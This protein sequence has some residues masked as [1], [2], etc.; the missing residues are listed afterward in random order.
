VSEAEIERLVADRVL[1]R[2]EID[3][4]QV[5][6]VWGKAIAS[7]ADSRAA[8][9]S[10]NGA[11]QLVYTAALQATVAVLFA[12]GLRPRSAA[13]HY[14][15]F[16]ALQKLGDRL[17]QHAIRLDRLRITRHRSVYE[18]YEVA[19]MDEQLIEARQVVA[20]AL[21]VLRA[22][23]IDARPGLEGQLAQIQG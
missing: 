16:F 9:L 18:P 1:A 22:A 20:E 15:A 2:E 8:G 3:D 23:I 14:H 17:R 10:S 7:L 12:H 6:T 5:A 4:E 19:D 11:F 13:N 21:P